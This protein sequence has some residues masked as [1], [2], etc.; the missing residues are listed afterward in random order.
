VKA[1]GKQLAANRRNAEKSTGPATSAGKAKSSRN[2]LK[3]GLLASEVVLD[4]ESREEFERF[5]DG[6]SE[7]LAPEGE[8]EIMLA[9]RII[10]AAWRLRR[11]G[12]I[13]QEMLEAMVATARN[14]R[15]P[16]EG[17]NIGPMLPKVDE[18][19]LTMGSV[20]A[21]HGS[22][23]GSL[24]N[25][26]RYESHLE[27]IIYKGLH[28]LQRLQ[29]ARNNQSVTPPAVLDVTVEGPEAKGGFGIWHR[30]KSTSRVNCMNWGNHE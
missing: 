27:R 2:A 21:G 10:A 25:L 29:A 13:E 22:N 11:A 16:F 7:R 30:A 28:E 3:H 4:E 6:M 20:L 1:T 8:L 5:R 18:V 17:L 12:R 15:A 23:W 19:L 26:A 9:Q 24:N 14:N